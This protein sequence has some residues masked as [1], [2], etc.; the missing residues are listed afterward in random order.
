MAFNFDFTGLLP[1]SL[2]E[3]VRSWLAEDT[4]SLDIGGFVVGGELQTAHVRELY[5]T[6]ALIRH[7]MPISRCTSR[8]PAC[9][10]G[11]H[12]LMP[13]SLS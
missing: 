7:I 13:C 12:S 5:S 11:G 9:S 1:C 10:R 2:S 6:D 8:A 4:P 3:L